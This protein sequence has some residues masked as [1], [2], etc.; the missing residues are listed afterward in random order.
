MDCG[1]GVGTVLSSEQCFRERGLL[2]SSHARD[3]HCGEILIV[4]LGIL[5]V[6]S[7]LVKH[8]LYVHGLQ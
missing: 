6:V 5:T 2:S 8:R 3:S 4:V 1:R 7:S